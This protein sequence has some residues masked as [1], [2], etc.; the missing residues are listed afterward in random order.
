MKVLLTGDRGRLG[1]AARDSLAEAG[2]EV[3]GFDVDRGDIRDAAAVRSALRGM[4]AVVHLAGLADDRA[5]AP[6]DVLTVN[7]LGTGNVLAGAQAE[8][9]GRVVYASSG[10]ALGMLEREPDYLPVDDRHRGMP[11]RPYGLSKWL[12]EEMCEAFTQ[13]TGIATICLRPVLVLDADG[14]GR[15]AGVSELPPPDTAAAW[16]LGVFVDVHDVAAAMVASIE[17]PDPGHARLLL[18]ADDIASERP[19]AE[20]AAEHLPNVPWRDGSPAEGRAALIDCSAA[21]ELL[22]W[23]PT[24]GWLDRP[25]AQFAARHELRQ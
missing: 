6:E 12:A 8:G 13:S 15:L 1:L 22:G 3:S 17:C 25:Q 20:L 16:H 21:K 9:V 10:K 19:S 23:K 7:L 5:G 11:A 4:D 14:Y 24:H 2:H 18:C